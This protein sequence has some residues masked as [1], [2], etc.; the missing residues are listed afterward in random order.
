MPAPIAS[1]FIARPERFDLHLPLTFLIDGSELPG[2][3]VNVSATGMLATFAHP[4]EVWTNGTLS[5]LAGDFYLTLPARVARTQ[6]LD[7]GLHF[8]LKTPNDH[9]ALSILLEVALALT[10]PPE[11]G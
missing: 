1:T 10:P 8:L 7:A 9:Q 4:L 5:F 11:L 6:D 3:C 2:H